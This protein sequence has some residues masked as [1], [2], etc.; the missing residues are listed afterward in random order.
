MGAG[1]GG[2]TAPLNGSLGVQPPNS[3]LHVPLELVHELSLLLLLH[4]HL[5]VFV[6][7][8]HVL[9]RGQLLA[10][11]R[12]KG[13]SPELEGTPQGCGTLPGQAVAVGSWEPLLKGMSPYWGIGDK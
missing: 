5:L 3:H 2:Q 9:Q 7:E 6:E 11:G 13:G 4:E 8:I 12:D 1:G 10:L